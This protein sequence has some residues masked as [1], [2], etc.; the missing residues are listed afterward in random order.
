[1]ILER[2]QEDLLLEMV[3]AARTAPRAEQQWHLGGEYQA[4]NELSGP[5]G[6]RPV[7]LRDV[8]ILHNAGYLD[9]VHENYVYGNDYVITAIGY[10]NADAIREAR[11]P[12]FRRQENELRRL[13]DSTVFREAYPNSF[14][15]WAEAETLLRSASSEREL[16]TIGHKA[17]EAMQEFATEI[18]ARYEPAEVDADPALVKRRLGAVIAMFRPQLGKAR[19]NLL[20]ALGDYAEAAIDIVQRQEHGAQ[21]EGH[22]LTWQDGRRVV[23][24]VA[25]L[26]YEFAV[27]CEEADPDAPEPAFP[28]PRH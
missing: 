4:P 26:M 27:S 21:K 25:S 10:Y 8:E 17:R 1:M 15:R 14:A 19:A 5:W 12:G 3:D 23:F 22:A 28:E 6:T 20:E 11:S 13:L 2:E 24:H 16:T 7:L 18:V 9:A